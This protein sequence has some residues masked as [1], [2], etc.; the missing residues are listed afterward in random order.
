MLGMAVAW[1]KLA[2]QRIKNNKTAL[3]YA[4]PWP[5]ND[6][7]APV[8]EPAPPPTEPPSPPPIDEPPTPPVNEPPPT[9]ESPPMRL[10]PA[11][12]DDPMQS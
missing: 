2:E 7:P 3:I 12:S 1:L 9:K 11:K 8:D 6:P 5:P 10:D 4:N